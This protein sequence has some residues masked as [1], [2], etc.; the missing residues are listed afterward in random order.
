VEVQSLLVEFDDLFQAPDSLPPSRQCNH[1]ISL[2]PGSQPFYIR[3]Y[4]YP[5]AL[6]D[7]IERQVQEMLSQGLIQPSSSMFSSPVLLVKKKDLSYRFCVDFRKLNS[8]TVKSKYPVPVIDQLLDELKHASWFTK[9]DL[10]AGF[11]QILL[12]ARDEHKTAFQ[13]H[14]GHYEFRVM[15]FGLTGAPGTFQ[16]AMNCTLAPG[17]RKFVFVFFDDILIYSRSLAEH[18]DHLRQVLAWLRR[19]SWKLKMSKCSFAQR[20][21]AYLEHVLSAEVSLPIP[22]KCRLYWTSHGQLSYELFV[23]SW[24]LRVTTA[25]L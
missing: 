7:E 18:I 2:V 1:A 13:T 19:D 24:G 20:S 25:N 23:D 9:L 4:R 17:L 14:L 6:K 15:A 10:R 5:P 11:H 21:V 12:Q 8:M 22:P 16:G 3:P